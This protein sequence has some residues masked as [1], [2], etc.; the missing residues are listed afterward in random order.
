M[1]KAKQTV[2][3]AENTVRV[4]RVVAAVDCGTVVNP[5]IVKAQIEGAIVYGLTAALYGEITVE[6][7]RVVQS[8]FHDYPL[9][10]MRDMP[11]VEVHLVP[12]S[13]P[14]TGIGEPGTPPI[15]AAVANAVFALTK[16][17]IRQLP[18]RTLPT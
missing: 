14:P 1:L 18:F 5:D 12:S 9:L 10:R 16:Q 17:R 2:T 4:N 3:R 13:A 11:R 15:A 7:G 8:N 6:K